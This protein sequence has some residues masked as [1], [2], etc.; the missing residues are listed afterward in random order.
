MSTISE[1]LEN[2]KRAREF[3][4]PMLYVERYI[5]IGRR[6]GDHILLDE[7][8]QPL[9]IQTSIC[10]QVG[11]IGSPRLNREFR[12]EHDEDK[13]LAYI[14]YPKLHKAYREY[15]NK[16]AT[17]RRFQY[18]NKIDSPN[19]N[20]TETIRSTDFEDDELNRLVDLKIGETLTLDSHLHIKRIQ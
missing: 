16:H 1:Q 19:M 14:L 8:Q 17:S 4:M 12:C 2:E 7:T 6:Y 9:H 10:T 15:L 18:V 11:L 3:D 13:D 20:L 5:E